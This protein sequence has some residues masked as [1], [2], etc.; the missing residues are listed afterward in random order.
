MTD[1]YVIQADNAKA[2]EGAGKLM[3]YAI[4]FVGA[5]GV[6]SSVSDV[7]I[8]WYTETAAWLTETGDY[9]ASFWPF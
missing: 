4:I 8:G 9:L 3:A 1:K 7:V 5:L 2:D 6:I